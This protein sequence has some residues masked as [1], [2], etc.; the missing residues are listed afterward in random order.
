LIIENDSILTRL[1]V[2][3]ARKFRFVL[4]IKNILELSHPYSLKIA[5]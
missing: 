1:H 4:V 3:G 5:M 2:L